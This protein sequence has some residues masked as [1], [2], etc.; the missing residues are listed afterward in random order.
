MTL[1]MVRA[2][3]TT[4]LL[5]S[6]MPSAGDIDASLEAAARAV[7]AS[8]VGARITRT[9]AGETRVYAL[10]GWPA[11]RGPWLPTAPLRGDGSPIDRF[12]RAWRTALPDGRW[13]GLGWAAW[14]E[15]ANGPV[16]WWSSGEAARTRTRDT[17][18][19]LLARLEADE[20]PD[21]PPRPGDHPASVADQ[22]RE[23]GRGIERAAESTATL[24]K[25]ALALGLLYVLSQGSSRRR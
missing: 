13:S 18:G 16:A 11:G 25:W 24:A 19:E 21:R 10:I 5:Q 4:A 9:H 14:T 6:S 2:V 1:A 8:V 20:V 22:A 23:L 12:M 15:A 7:N 17:P 3:E